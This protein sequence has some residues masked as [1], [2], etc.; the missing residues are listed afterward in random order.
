MYHVRVTT[1]LLADAARLC[2]GKFYIHGAGWDTIYAP[3]V[4]ATY[5]AFSVVA[6][7]EAE[8][9]AELDGATFEIKMLDEDGNPTGT[10]ATGNHRPGD[11]SQQTPGLPI[12]AS[13]AVTFPA[14]TFARFGIYQF[15]ISVNGN[16]LYTLKFAVR[17]PQ[18]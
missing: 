18:Q 2:D 1:A 5:S 4:P 8:S 16:E 13:V 3:A 9:A 6:V 17:T 7:V 12:T 15:I 11:P 14:V 10:S